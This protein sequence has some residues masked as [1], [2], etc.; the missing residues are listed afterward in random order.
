MMVALALFARALWHPSW[1]PVPFLIAALA[2][3]FAAIAMKFSEDS[4]WSLVLAALVYSASFWAASVFLVRDLEDGTFGVVIG[5]SFFI[6][7]LG[8]WRRDK[9]RSYIIVTALILAAIS[10]GA[11]ILASLT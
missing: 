2:P 9:P 4:D 8:A 11:A 5:M 10:V 6:I 3:V 7:F 1:S